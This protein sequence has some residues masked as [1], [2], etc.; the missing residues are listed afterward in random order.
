MDQTGYT[1][2]PSAVNNRKVCF[3]NHAQKLAHLESV[4]FTFYGW[5]KRI[6]FWT[7]D[8]ALSSYYV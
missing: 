2:L 4:D 3:L 6:Y 5:L 7:I 1:Y 8:F